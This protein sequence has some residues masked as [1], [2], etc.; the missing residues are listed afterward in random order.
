[1]PCGQLPVL[2]VEGHNRLIGQ[3]YAI[4]RY[5][6]Y[7]LDKLER[8]EKLLKKNNNGDGWFVGDTI[9]I[10]DIGFYHGTTW[11]EVFGVQVHWDKY[12]KLKSH[13]ERFESIPQ[14]KKWMEI[15]PNTAW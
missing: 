12:P 9:T 10:A 4:L 3:S 11:P 2:E 8:F 7:K 1:M 15:R 5:L 14:I 6:A 13:R